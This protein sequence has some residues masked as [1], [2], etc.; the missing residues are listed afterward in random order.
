MNLRSPD[1]LQF[2][3]KADCSPS[4]CRWGCSCT[5]SWQRSSFL[6]HALRWPLAVTSELFSS[7][8]AVCGLFLLLPQS[9]SPLHM[10]RVYETLFVG[11][12][13]CTVL[14]EALV[15]LPCEHHPRCGRPC[16]QGLPG[17]RLARRHCGRAPWPCSAVEANWL[18]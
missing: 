14:C 10:L 11:V 2:W 13:A 12:R 16:F 3:L 8:H 4:P 5:C 1:P 9:S 6:F 17:R 18:I 7:P 15:P